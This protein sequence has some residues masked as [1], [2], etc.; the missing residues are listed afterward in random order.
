LD[1]L[2][3]I[4]RLPQLK[5]FFE[6]ICRKSSDPKAKKVLEKVLEVAKYINQAI[7]DRELFLKWVNLESQLLGY[8]GILCIYFVF[9]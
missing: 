8:P 3:P 1:L 2:K 6:K 9:D 5:L 7:L 4:Q